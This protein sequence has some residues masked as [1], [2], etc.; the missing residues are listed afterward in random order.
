MSAVMVDFSAPI[1]NS[2]LNEMI[3][4]SYRDDDRNSIKLVDKYHLLL[5]DLDKLF[6]CLR[7]LIFKQSSEVKNYFF[8][9]FFTI[10]FAIF[11]VMVIPWLS[12]I[13]FTKSKVSLPSAFAKL[14]KTLRTPSSDRDF[15]F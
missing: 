1:A 4:M 6:D 12:P 9:Y 14:W 13:F 7:L 8:P 2:Y 5:G 15:P 11:Y 10:R 3:A